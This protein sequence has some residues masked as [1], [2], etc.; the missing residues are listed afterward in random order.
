M[1]FSLGDRRE[2]LV[3]QVATYRPKTAVTRLVTESQEH[4]KIVW[5]KRTLDAFVD[6]VER[7][8]QF[9]R[10][11]NQTV[12][13]IYGHIGAELREIVAG[14]F[15]HEYPRK[16][17]VKADVYDATIEDIG[18]VARF[19]LA[20]GD[21]ADFNRIMYNSCRQYKVEQKGFW[22]RDTKDQLM[23]LKLK[24]QERYT[25]LVEAALMAKKEREVP[26]MHIKKEACCMYGSDWCRR[27]AEAFVDRVVEKN[28][29]D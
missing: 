24:F 6:F 29:R 14:I 12:N 19:L 10:T 26:A 23:V 11:Y 3:D 2:S 1:K 28:M 22:Y 5:E 27:E 8:L 15:L 20:P 16:F 4:L 9:Q 18:N 21:M 13:H 17:K 7:L 25:F